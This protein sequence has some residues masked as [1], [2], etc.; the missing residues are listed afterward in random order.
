MTNADGTYT[1][2]ENGVVTFVPVDGLTTD[3]TE[4]VY[5]VNDNDGN[6]SNEGTIR[7]TYEN[8]DESPVAVTDEDLDNP[9]GEDVV[10]NVVAND[11]DADGTIDPTTVDLDPS[12]PGIQDTLTNADGTYTCLLYTSP[13]P[14][15]R[16][17]SRMP[18]S[19]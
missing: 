13:S 9:V 16:Q 4:I 5:T 1:V 14:R 10:I 8:A 12:T 11:T 18:S 2:D 6:T 19:A 3:P 17:K 15:D 7:I